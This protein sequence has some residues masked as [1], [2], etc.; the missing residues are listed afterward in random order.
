MRR[1]ASCSARLSGLGSCFLEI[2]DIEIADLRLRNSEFGRNR[3]EFVLVEGIGLFPGPPDIHDPG[4]TV[5]A[6]Y[7]VEEP[8]R[9]PGP[10]GSES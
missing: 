10:A 6:G 2:V 9:G 7:P 1:P 3:A 4:T 5:S 8:A